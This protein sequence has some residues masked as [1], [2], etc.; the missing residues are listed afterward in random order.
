[1]I[2]SLDNHPLEV[3]DSSQDSSIERKLGP[4]WGAELINLPTL[5]YT[6]SSLRI[7]TGHHNW[8]QV[9]VYRDAERVHLF[10]NSVAI[11]DFLSKRSIEIDRAAA[12][13][14]SFLGSTQ[15]GR[16]LFKDSFVV[17]P[18]STFSID[19]GKAI[20]VTPNSR[21][22][23]LAEESDYS[24]QQFVDRYYEVL[25]EKFRLLREIDK[26]VYVGVSGGFDSRISLGL[27]RKYE[28]EVRAFYIGN[29]RSRGLQTRDYLSASEVAESLGFKIDV[30]PYQ[31]SSV[32]QRLAHELQ[33]NILGGAEAMRLC[34]FPDWK[35]GVL[36]NGAWGYLVQS[37]KIN[38]PNVKDLLVM[39]S[40]YFEWLKHRKSRVIA[41]TLFGCS[42]ARK[43]LPT[44]LKGIGEILESEIA[45]V[46]DSLDGLSPDEIVV[47]YT[48]RMQAALTSSGV[49]E[50]LENRHLPF[51][52]YAE[53]I[54]ET[55]S[56]YYCRALYDRSYARAAL[57]Q[58]GYQFDN[59]F[60]QGS[61]AMISIGYIAK[62]KFL[63]SYLIRGQGV[64][65]YRSSYRKHRREIQSLLSDHNSILTESE[66][67][68]VLRMTDK[69]SLD[70]SVI[71]NLLKYNFVSAKVR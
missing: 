53:L 2:I 59:I 17:P 28:L 55:S 36:L 24:E 54:P 71:L 46:L 7:K 27:C 44:R 40:L 38:K 68:L 33:H 47:N 19:D 14:L 51:S 29:A 65:N 18:N 6:R 25:E 1:M 41:N 56:S 4:E 69:G 21:T 22:R 52:I 3:A 61:R 66:L 39:K 35:Q 9:F 45:P 8:P 43:G 23:Y 10:T 42:Y 70:T 57:D 5:S 64:M 60:E 48:A 32:E 62:L 34:S 16:W 15:D 58:L 20:V 13:A 26:P 49:F 11:F 50:S 31:Q 63:A 37:P 12:I 67:N 30:L